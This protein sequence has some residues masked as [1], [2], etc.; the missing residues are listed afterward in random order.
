MP[1]RTTELQAIELAPSHHAG[2]AIDRCAGFARYPEQLPVAMG[3]GGAIRATVLPSTWRQGREMLWRD[4]LA[5]ESNLLIA[6][7]LRG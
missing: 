6:V 1:A 2:V 4:A 3:T 7:V 5:G